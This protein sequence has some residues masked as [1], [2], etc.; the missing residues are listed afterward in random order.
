MEVS[1]SASFGPVAR[2]VTAE[3]GTKMTWATSILE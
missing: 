1:E 2:P 3:K